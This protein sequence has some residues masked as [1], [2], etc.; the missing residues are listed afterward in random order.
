MKR[1][2]LGIERELLNV[3]KFPAPQAVILTGVRRCGKSTLLRQLMKKQKEYYYFNFED[4]RIASFGV[5]DFDKLEELLPF[6]YEQNHNYFL[7]EI[8]NVPKWELFV[9]KLLQYGEKCVI[10]G[11]NASLLSRELGTR[12]TGRHLNY[13]LFPFSYSEYL[14]YYHQNPCAATLKEYLKNGGFP[15]YLHDQNSLFLQELLKDILT[16]D[17][18]VRYKIRESRKMQE[19]AIYILTS[20]G[21]EFSYN[22]LA[23]LF[24]FG[25]VNTAISYVS[26]LEDSYLIFTIPKFSYSYRQQLIGQKKAYGIDTGLISANSVTFS[27]DEGRALENAV[28]L[29]LRR[30]N[31]DIFFFKEKRECD[32][33]VKEKNKA[34]EAIQVCWEIN[35]DNQEREISGIKEAMEKTNLSK[36]T[37]IT[38]NQEDSLCGIKVLPFWKWAVRK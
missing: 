4:Q 29:Q 20:A 24:D 32:F 13:E 22:N 23:K 3:I 12:L 37:I 19:L 31:R 11:S 38:F 36:G 1:L 15:E 30:N 18:I 28:F 17:I 5:E 8:Q 33:L 14:Q 7:D 9:R 10:T 34:K 16:R 21:K 6:E 2:P 26:Y 35:S 27:P 25:S